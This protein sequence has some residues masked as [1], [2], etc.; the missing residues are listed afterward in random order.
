MEKIPSIYK[1]IFKQLFSSS[2]IEP[3][4]V[5]NGYSLDVL[6]QVMDI[7]YTK[8]KKKLVSN[9]LFLSNYV[10]FLSFI[11]TAER[12]RGE[13]RDVHQIPYGDVVELLNHKMEV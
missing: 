12:I 6:F 11:M 9:E 3:I 10:E 13:K 5:V 4:K 8:E 7:M 2:E 1:K